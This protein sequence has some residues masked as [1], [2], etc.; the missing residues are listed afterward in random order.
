MTRNT[1]DVRLP[2]LPAGPYVVYADITHESGYAQTLTD[3]VHVPE[4][5]ST[6]SPG[7]TAAPECDPDDSFSRRARRSEARPNP[8]ASLADGLGMVWQR[9]ALVTGQPVLLNFQ[10]EL[11]MAVPQALEPYMGMLGTRGHPARRR[12]G[13]RSHPSLPAFLDGGPA[14][15]RE[16]VPGPDERT[17]GS[18]PARPVGLPALSPFPSSSPGRPV[19]LWVQVKVE[20][21]I[22]TAAFDADVAPLG[23][24]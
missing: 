16:Q 3:R 5:P 2:P 17:H 13:L 1:F 10:V 6:E 21:R 22:L 14:S 23:V 9:E 11:A 18:Q 7:G 24:R 8:T 4:A 12:I 20:N 15:A 19:S